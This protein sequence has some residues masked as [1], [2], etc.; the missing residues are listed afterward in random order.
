MSKSSP[1]PPAPAN[2]AVPVALDSILQR[3]SS[4]NAFSR[5]ENGRY[6]NGEWKPYTSQEYA[7]MF[8]RAFSNPDKPDL[9]ALS[10]IMA[11]ENRVIED[12]RVRAM[13]ERQQET[14]DWRRQI[15]ETYL[16]KF[17]GVN[18]QMLPPSQYGLPA[19]PSSP[20]PNPGPNPGDGLPVGGGKPPPG[21]SPGNPGLPPPGTPPGTPPPGTPPGPTPPTEPP[22]GGGK[23][24]PTHDK[25]LWRFY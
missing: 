9:A 17:P 24:P 10:E 2:P 14:E 15:G 22:G 12:P 23:P 18:R 5:T 11:A 4:E 19:T 6:V 1:K 25:N 3:P 16:A 21:W 8:A 20:W 13:R 7:S